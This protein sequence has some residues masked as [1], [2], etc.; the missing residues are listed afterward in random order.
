MLRTAVGFVLTLASCAMAQSVSPL[1]PDTKLGGR[2]T[3]DLSAE[4]WKW[5]MAS[6]PEINPV[7]DASGKHCAVVQNGQ[8]WFLAGGFGSARITRQCTIPADKYIFFPVVNMVYWP[9]EEGNGFTCE[10]A[11]KSAT[12]NNDTAVDLFASVDA[13]SYRMSRAIG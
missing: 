5:A 13:S 4:W 3:A 10:R 6:P 12:F 9:R 1:A 8:V 11:K 7:R 2:S